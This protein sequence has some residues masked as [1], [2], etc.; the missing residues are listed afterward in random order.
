VIK[1]SETIIGNKNAKF[2]VK[3]EKLRA[4]TSTY[5]TLTFTIY[6]QGKIVYQKNDIKNL[7]D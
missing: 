4:N 2:K 1:V 7:Y 6:H 3:I 5:K